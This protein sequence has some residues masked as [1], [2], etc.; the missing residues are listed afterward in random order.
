MVVKVKYELKPERGHQSIRARK[1]PFESKQQV[2]KSSLE[3]MQET[4]APK[5]VPT[6]GCT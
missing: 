4:L 5:N 2:K 6:E 3:V 1:S